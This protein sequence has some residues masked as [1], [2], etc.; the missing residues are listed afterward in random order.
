MNRTSVSS[1][2]GDTSVEFDVSTNYPLISFVSMVA[3][4]PDWFVRISG[5]PLLNS[6]GYWKIH[7]E[8][9]L[10]AYDAGT[11]LGLRPTSGNQDNTADNLSIT[12]LSSDRADTDF[13]NG[14]HFQNSKV[15]GKFII[16]K[17]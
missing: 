12:L 2:D 9:A 14:V 3:P 10:K 17:L 6:E 1:G 5:F 15:I 8:I 4:S 11:D 16:D 7:E 13:E